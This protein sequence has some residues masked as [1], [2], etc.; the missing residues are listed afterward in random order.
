MR[1]FIVYNKKF[2]SIIKIIPTILT[3]LTMFILIT[4]M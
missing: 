3:I 4:Q 1:I 2:K